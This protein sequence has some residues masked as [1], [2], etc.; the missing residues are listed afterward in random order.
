MRVTSFP[1]PSKWHPSNPPSTPK[2]ELPLHSH[3][4]DDGVI[5]SLRFDSVRL[6]IENYERQL[7]VREL[8]DRICQSGDHRSLCS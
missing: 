1:M 3:L 6:D 7:A 4:P 2:K 8:T 5:K